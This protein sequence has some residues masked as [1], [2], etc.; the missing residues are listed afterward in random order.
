MEKSLYSPVVLY[1]CMYLLVLDYETD[2]ERKR[3]DYTVEKWQGELKIRK[4]RG[5]TIVVE[6]DKKTVEKFVEDLCARLERSEEKIEMYKIEEHKPEIEKNEKKL[7]YE[8]TEDEAYIKKFIDYLMTKLN[9][10]YQ[11]KSKIGKVYKMYT[12]K[13]QTNLEVSI[14]N[15]D[16]ET[17]VTITLEGYGDV[18]DFISNKIDGEMKTFLERR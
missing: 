18:V 3:I 17:V 9:A 11:Y 4:P 2:A 5:T 8:S 7:F 15:K 13:G 16:G 6:G 10:S 1:F 12:K 14:K